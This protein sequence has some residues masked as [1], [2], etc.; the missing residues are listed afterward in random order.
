TIARYP[1]DRRI[2]DLVRE[3]RVQ[4][5]RFVQLWESSDMPPPRGRSRHKIIDHPAVGHIT[6]DCD[7][8]IDAADDLR[9]TIY[10][11]EPGTD[12][13][14]RLALAIVIGIQTVAGATSDSNSRG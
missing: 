9:I 4:S 11:A 10:T 3:L 6:L 8:L 7:T 5:P 12:D 2:N 14:D 13:A 1:S